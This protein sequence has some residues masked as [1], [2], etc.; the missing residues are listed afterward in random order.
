MQEP[1][2]PLAPINPRQPY[3]L[4][5]TDTGRLIASEPHGVL[6]VRGTLKH[7]NDGQKVAAPPMPWDFPLIAQ[8][9]ACGKII[10]KNESLLGNW[11]HAE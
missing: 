7:A 8:C 11:C 3:A 4:R 2:P 9:A 6:P 1:S 5:M 10:R